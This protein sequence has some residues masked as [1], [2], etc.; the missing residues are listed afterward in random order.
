MCGW[1]RAIIC[2]PHYY[3]SLRIF[4]HS[5]GPASC[6][7]KIIR[8]LDL[9]LH[10]LPDSY[11][12]TSLQGGFFWILSSSLSP[13]TLSWEWVMNTTL[14]K[15]SEWITEDHGILGH[16]LRRIVID[17]LLWHSNAMGNLDRNSRRTSV[18]STV[19]HLILY[20]LFLFWKIVTGTFQKK[21]RINVKTN[22][23]TH[24][25]LLKE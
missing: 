5:Y 14:K 17:S 13:S 3:L 12:K 10:I 18:N 16:R 15:V 1:G 19:K 20:M 9:L 8:G 11:D 4:R 23:P 2:L 24:H 7:W 25:S 22:Q 6:Y 21:K